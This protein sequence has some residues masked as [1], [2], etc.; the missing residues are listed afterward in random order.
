MLV[1]LTRVWVPLVRASATA[2]KPARLGFSPALRV[3][4]P[5]ELHAGRGTSL[6]W[7][8]RQAVGSVSERCRATCRERRPLAPRRPGRSRLGLLESLPCLDEELPRLLRRARGRLV[9]EARGPLEQRR[10][11]RR[12]GLPRTRG[13][14]GPGVHRA[15]AAHTRQPSPRRR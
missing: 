7:L 13:A 4:V 3:S 1:R 10:H 14:R 15:A 11:A 6:L 12:D 9:D 8:R 2:A 5:A